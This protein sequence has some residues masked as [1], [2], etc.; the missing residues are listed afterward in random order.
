MV[1]RLIHGDM[2][3]PHAAGR[4]H[5]SLVPHAMR[6]ICT[7]RAWQSPLEFL[8]LLSARWQSRIGVE[9]LNAFEVDSPDGSRPLA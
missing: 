2:L 4:L 6:E 9:M 5:L 1:K 7:A 8:G 3:Q